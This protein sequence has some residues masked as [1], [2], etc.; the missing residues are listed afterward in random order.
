MI[1]ATCKKKSILLN[2]V[3]NAL[4]QHKTHG[5]LYCKLLKSEARFLGVIYV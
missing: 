3:P 1:V 4:S 2:Y 5:I